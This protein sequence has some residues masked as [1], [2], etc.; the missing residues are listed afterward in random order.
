MNMFKSLELMEK[1]GVCPNCGNDLLGENQGG[2]VVEEGAF[3]RFCKC[4]FDL[5]IHSDSKAKEY[6]RKEGK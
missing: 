3:R 2:I 4:G 5:V 1:Y 6:L